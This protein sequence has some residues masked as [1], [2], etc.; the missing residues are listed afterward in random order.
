MADIPQYRRPYWETQPPLRH[1]PYGSTRTRSPLE[2]LIPLQQTLTEVTGPLFGA[3]FV[4]QGD[5]DL[6]CHGSGQPIGQRIIVAGRVTDEDGRPVRDALMEVWQANASGR[7][8]HARDQGNAALDPNFSGVGRTATDADGR[9]SFLTVRPGSYPWKNHFNAWRPAHIHFS[10]FGNAYATRLV[11]QMYFPGD[12]MLPFDP[13]FN[14][15][16][17]EIARGK[18]I[19]EFDWA[20]TKADFAHAFRFDIV[21]RGRDS[22]PWE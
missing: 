10:L 3:A 17:N 1:E 16:A 9:Y 7:Y 4:R 15:T 5:N 6:T 13:I 20:A 18:L 14:A 19:A 8:L 22:T 21:L 2:P 12:D 11:T